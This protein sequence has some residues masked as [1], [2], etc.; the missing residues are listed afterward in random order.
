MARFNKKSFISPLAKILSYQNSWRDSTE[1]CRA[2]PLQ[3]L[4]SPPVSGVISVTAL[5]LLLQAWPSMHTDTLQYQFFRLWSFL[6]IFGSFL[7]FFSLEWPFSPRV[8]SAIFSLEFLKHY[9]NS[10]LN[11]CFVRSILKFKFIIGICLFGLQNSIWIMDSVWFW[12]NSFIRV[13]EYV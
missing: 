3:C 5:Y 9:L 12:E 6:F 4:I 8:N 2:S 7:S 10:V 13:L 11:N 1:K